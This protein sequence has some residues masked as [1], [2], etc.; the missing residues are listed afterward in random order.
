MR[1][2][3]PTVLFFSWSRVP[4]GE[5]IVSVNGALGEGGGGGGGS[6]GGT[7]G[8]GQDGVITENKARVVVGVAGVQSENGGILTAS[9]KVA[10]GAARHAALQN[11]EGR[12]FCSQVSYAR[13][14]VR[15]G[16]PEDRGMCSEWSTRT[17]N[18][19][20]RQL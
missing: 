5:T 9:N 6:V 19:F 10:A 8:S 13:Y 18:E 1:N 17:M 11:P 4:R 20:S 16:I 7:S 12:F 14:W 2:T 15:T 3:G